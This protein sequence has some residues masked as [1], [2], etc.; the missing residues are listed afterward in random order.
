MG[1]SPR[2]PREAMVAISFAQGLALFGLWRALE[3]GFWPSAMPAANF[4]LWTIALTFPTFLLF[5]LRRGN[6]KA[7][8]IRAGGAVA[9]LALLAVYVGWQAT[10]HGAFPVDS[11]VSIAVATL[12]GACFLI[13]LFLFDGKL[14]PD[15]ATL[16]ANAW[17][18]ALTG[19][20]SAALVG[21]TAL[22]LMLWGALFSAVGV[23][24]F[25][26]LFTEDRFLFPVLSVAFGLGVYIFRTMHGVL[27][28][29]VALL[30]GLLRLLLPLVL[31][32]TVI[33]LAAL[34]FTGLAPLWETGNGT[35]LLLFLNLFGVLFLNGVFQPGREAPYPMLVQRLLLP[36]IALLPVLS[37]LAAYGLYLRVAQYGWTVERCWAATGN[38]L[39]ALASIGYAI[40]AFRRGD[41]W[42][43]TME[44]ANRVQAWVVLAVLLLV[45][46][47]LLDFRAIAAGSQL[48]RLASG[49]IIIDEL[50][51]AYAK[52]HLARSGY[53]SM[54]ELAGEIEANDPGQANRIRS[55]WVPDGDAEEAFWNR[56]VLRPEPFA[57]PDDL[58][59]AI[60]EYRG[61]WAAMRTVPAMLARLHLDDD[62]QP[63]YVLIEES[64]GADR[65]RFSGTCFYREGDRW[66]ALRVYGI[67]TG[68]YYG[69]DRTAFDAAPLATL[70]VEAVPHPPPRFKAIRI[71]DYMLAVQE[72][73]PDSWIQARTLATPP[74]G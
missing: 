44:L 49:T 47:P 60:D 1:E 65:W 55:Y 74:D 2:L 71:G 4:P 23:D 45:N 42:R 43:A 29:I 51:L 13:L 27:D 11:L 12:V 61:R 18:S 66:A 31:A 62:A 48:G 39:L 22:I 72:N 30:E 64:F 26:D 21:G 46:T 9:V 37:L 20:L 24:F 69:S 38:A 63:E 3:D 67:G 6:F 57:V 14:Q 33:F 10:P 15:Y 58:R 68:R 32:V 7:L 19:A 25:M 35:A 36:G 40:G 8:A 17:R 53:R 34:P 56:V 73:P 70:P 28:R 59:E 54:H 41:G 5:A 50:D 16:F 52:S